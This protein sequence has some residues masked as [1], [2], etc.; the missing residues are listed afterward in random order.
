MINIQRFTFNDLQVNTYLLWDETKECVIIDAACYTEDE[1]KE[2][3]N[4]IN[5]KN[6]KP[7]KIVNTHNHVDHI[8]GN[9]FIKKQYNIPLYAN[10]KGD[11]FI[12]MAQS[13]GTIFGLE[14]KETVQPDHSLEEGEILS[15]GNSGLKV[16][17]TPGHADGS[18][19]L[20]ASDEKFL[21]A[22]DVL[23]AGGIGRTDLPTGD[24]DTL[25]ETITQKLYP[26]DDEV[27]VLPGHGPETTIGE[28]KKYNPFI[29]HS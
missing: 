28:E 14:V 27:R 24:F 9:P 20:Y 2:L 4:F 19:C 3:V 8:L 17:Y 15:F 12:R 11:L 26:L 10:K 1:Q 13:S 22:G 7:V 6:L 25:T 21:I 23:F 16:F 29:T 18:I 5:R